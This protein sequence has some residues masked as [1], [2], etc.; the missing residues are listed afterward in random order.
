MTAPSIDVAFTPAEVRPTD[1][2]LVVDVLRAGSTIVAALEAGFERVL[3]VAD[4]DGAYRLK[5]PG[6]ALAGERGCRPI[7]N[8]DYGNSPRA[9]RRA[10]VAELVLCTTN[11]TPA[12]LAA[13]AAADEVLVASLLNLDAVVG[14]V[15]PGRDVTVVCSGTDR[16]FALEDAYVAG[17]LVARL[18]RKCTDAATAAARLAGSYPGAFEPLAHSADAAVLRA[19][20]Q[21]ADIGFCARESVYDVVARVSGAADGVAVVER[22][23]PPA[24]HSHTPI[25]QERSLA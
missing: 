15:P 12:V 11:G 22:A 19:T 6:R 18:E 4:V 7:E 14:A 21:A 3:C 2:A 17:R 9:L 16:R 25:G 1:V 20:D 5:G 23:T 24:T 10:P 8:F 13:A